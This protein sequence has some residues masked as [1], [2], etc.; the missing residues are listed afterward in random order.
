MAIGKKRPRPAKVPS[1]NENRDPGE[2]QPTPQIP[3]E[4]LFAFLEKEIKFT[5]NSYTIKDGF[6]FSQ[7]KIERHRIDVWDKQA[8]DYYTSSHTIKFSY[9]L[10]YDPKTQTIQDFTVPANLPTS[11][12]Y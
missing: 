1:V 5:D 9:F 10:H 11:R 3:R 4:V 6:L 12:Q 8:T 7:D 2:K